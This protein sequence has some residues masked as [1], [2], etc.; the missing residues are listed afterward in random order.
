MRPHIHYV[1]QTLKTTI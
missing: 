1:F